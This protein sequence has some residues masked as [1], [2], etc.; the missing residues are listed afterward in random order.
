MVA[1][2]GMGHSPNSCGKL[3]N[4]CI[5]VGFKARGKNTFIGIYN[6]GF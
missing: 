6:G 3:C 2:L 4:V 5:P 1:K